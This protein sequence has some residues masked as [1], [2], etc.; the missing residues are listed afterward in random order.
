MIWRW[1]IFVV[2]IDCPHHP[3]YLYHDNTEQTS[4]PNKSYRLIALLGVNIV[5]NALLIFDT[6]AFNNL[7]KIFPN[8]QSISHFL[9]KDYLGGFDINIMGDEGNL[10]A[11]QKLG[12]NT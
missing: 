9:D 8:L 4:Q 2:L 11:Q 1:L 10:S 5:K 3:L 7:K 6:F 12:K